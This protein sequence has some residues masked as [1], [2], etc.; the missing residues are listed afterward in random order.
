MVCLFSSGR[1]RSTCW[2]G[3][4]LRV[5]HTKWGGPFTRYGDVGWV[6]HPCPVSDF[7]HFWRSNN[8]GLKDF[9]QQLQKIQEKKC[10]KNYDVNNFTLIMKGKSGDASRSETDEIDQESDNSMY[11]FWFRI[12]NSKPNLKKLTIRWK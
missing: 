2:H 8:N 11:D 5:I 4:D 1:N 7:S 3:G 6:T 10:V 12:Q 9:T